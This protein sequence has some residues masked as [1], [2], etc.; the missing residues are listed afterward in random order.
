MSEWINDE[1]IVD[2]IYVHTVSYTPKET[3]IQLEHM[4]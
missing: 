3:R 4:S 1:Q 2:S